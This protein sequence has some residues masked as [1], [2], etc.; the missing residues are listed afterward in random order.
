[1]ADGL[2]AAAGSGAASGWVV[3]LEEPVAVVMNNVVTG[4]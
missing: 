2:T 1:M 3:L 4:T